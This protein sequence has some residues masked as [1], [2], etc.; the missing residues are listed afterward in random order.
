MAFR[1]NAYK[2][3]STAGAKNYCCGARDTHDD[4]TGK[5]D[6]F[7]KGALYNAGF[8]IL[9]RSGALQ[10]DDAMVLLHDVDVRRHAKACLK[11][12]TRPGAG[13]AVGAAHGRGLVSV[14]SD[15]ACA[16]YSQI[17]ALTANALDYGQCV[18]DQLRHFGARHALIKFVYLP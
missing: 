9:E 12:A 18:D 5:P 10:D 1:E 15:S 8:R 2:T 13:H 7:N 11:P 6:L 17:R 14:Q 3:I 16:R 4:T